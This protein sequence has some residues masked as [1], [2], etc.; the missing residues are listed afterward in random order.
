LKE[1]PKE[2]EILAMLYSERQFKRIRGL[3]Q[4]CDNPTKKVLDYIILLTQLDENTKVRRTAVE[5]LGILLM[6][7]HPEN[8]IILKA[9]KSALKNDPSYVVK[10]LARELIDEQ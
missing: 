7:Q 2:E 3:K 1:P 4:A 9:I 10:E 8:E 5:V 6:T